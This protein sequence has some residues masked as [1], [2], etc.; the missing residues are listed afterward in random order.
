V[1]HAGV[2]SDRLPI[3]IAEG[4]QLHEVPAGQ[5]PKFRGIA[6][7]SFDRKSGC[8]PDARTGISESWH[9]SEVWGSTLGTFSPN[10][11]WDGR[12]GQT[13][14][15]GGCSERSSVP[16]DNGSSLECAKR[17]CVMSGCVLRSEK[18]REV[19]SK[20]KMLR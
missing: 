14:D 18:S 8:D 10:Q 3:D 9:T 12:S 2:V 16:S 5:H 19:M 4:E 15:L 7:Q 17:K 11:T 6:R 13:Q 20:V 1:Q